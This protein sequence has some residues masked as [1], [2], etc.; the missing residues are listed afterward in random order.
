MEHHKRAPWYW[1]HIVQETPRDVE[2]SVRTYDADDDS[3][4]EIETENRIPIWR[5]CL[6]TG[7]SFILTVNCDGIMKLGLQRDIAL[8]KRIT[9]SILKP[10]VSSLRRKPPYWKLTLR[11]TSGDSSCYKI[12]FSKLEQSDKL[13]MTRMS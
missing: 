1:N 7:S 6:K 3:N 12:K 11:H 4:I 10:E 2:H 9:L 8:L 5:L 13:M